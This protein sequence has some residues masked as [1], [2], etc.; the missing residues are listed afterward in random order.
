MWFMYNKSTKATKNEL[1]NS[2]RCKFFSIPRCPFSWHSMYQQRLVHPLTSFCLHSIVLDETVLFPETSLAGLWIVPLPEQMRSEGPG[3]NS[4]KGAA[5]HCERWQVTTT[6]EQRLGHCCGEIPFLM[7]V[8]HFRH[9]LSKFNSPLKGLA[10]ENSFIGTSPSSSKIEHT[11]RFRGM[12]YT[13]ISHRFPEQR[14]KEA[15]DRKRDYNLWRERPLKGKQLNSSAQ[16]KFS[17]CHG[18]VL[19]HETSCAVT[20]D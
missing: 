4:W 2:R 6:P 8:F 14:I 7:L 3:C 9:N 1:I 10:A 20:V 16:L 13:G 5:R 15:N 17:S 18:N 11:G 19:R 12:S